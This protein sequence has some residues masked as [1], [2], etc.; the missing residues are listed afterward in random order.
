[1]WE[2]VEKKLSLNFGQFSAS[3]IL[4][5][6]QS[7]GRNGFGAFSA[8]ESTFCSNKFV[9]FLFLLLVHAFV[10]SRIDYCNVLLAGPLGHR[11]LRPSYSVFHS[12]ECSSPRL[13]SDTRKFDRGLSQLMHVD[14][15]WLD[16]PERVKCITAS[17]TKLLSTWRTTAFLSPMWPV[18]HIFVEPVVNRHHLVV[19]RHNLRTY[20]W[21]S[22][23]RSCWPGCPEHTEWR[24]ARYG[25]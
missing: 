23:I 12:F 21:S 10:T 1:M 17:T 11:K 24:S 9:F 4:R 22:G 5:G 8:W 13:V 6:G 20:I 19:P 15:Y 2:A 18:D 25:A 14:L 7:L 16:V 3:K